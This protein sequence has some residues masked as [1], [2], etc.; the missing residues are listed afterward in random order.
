MQNL[1]PDIRHLLL[2]LLVGIF[3]SACVKPSYINVNYRLPEKSD[4]IRGQKVFL[5]MK[6]QR[7]DPVIFGGKAQQEF[8]DRAGIFSLY[9]IKG[10]KDSLRVGPFD[11]S[12]L[13][14][15]AFKLRMEN[16][17]IDVLAEKKEGA[18]VIEIAL[19]R[20]FMDLKG[21]KWEADISYEARLIRNHNV[22]T[23]QNIS[24]KAERMKLM[25][26]GAG[27]KVLGDIFTDIVNKL[28]LNKLFMETI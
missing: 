19:Q 17:G 13:F 28:D 8:K 24:G 15:E 25:G 3:S 1:Y 11:L 2:F 23:T 5:K 9:L 16:A 26:P 18:P 27:E 10:E 4:L 14:A 20:F 7:S 12:S 6:D 21:R 22:L